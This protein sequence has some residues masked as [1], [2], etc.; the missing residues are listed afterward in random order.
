VRI[1]IPFGKEKLY[2]SLPDTYPYVVVPR[3]EEL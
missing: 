3:A 2:L 1:S